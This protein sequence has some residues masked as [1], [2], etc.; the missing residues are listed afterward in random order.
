MSF[1]TMVKLELNVSIFEISTV[2]SFVYYSCWVQTLKAAP[3]FDYTFSSFTFC[4]HLACF[5]ETGSDV[6]VNPRALAWRRLL[7]VLLFEVGCVV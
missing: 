1:E 4:V 7:F 3:S 2:F 5:S 6:I